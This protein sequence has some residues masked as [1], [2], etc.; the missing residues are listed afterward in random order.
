MRFVLE[1]YLLRGLPRE[2][3]GLGN[4]GGGGGDIPAAFTPAAAPWA[5]ATEGPWKVGDA[6]K[7][8]EWWETI[9]E[10][11]AREHV[12]AKG[13]KNPAELALAN[14][15]LTKMQRGATDVVG[16][17]GK[18]ADDNAWN[19]FYTKL[20]RPAAPTDYN[21]TFGEGVQVDAAMLDFGKDLFHKM[22][23][24]NNR[25][26]QAAN[27]WNEFI[28][29]QNEAHIAEAN[30][31]NTE[32]LAA[33]ELKWGAD[34]NTNRAAGERVVQSL[35]LGAEIMDA[36]QN[37]IGA[38]P[39]V[40]LLALIGRK[41]DEGTLLGNGGSNSDPN[42]PANMTKEQANAKIAELQGDVE[43]QKK[44]TDGKHPGHKE[45]VDRMQKLFMKA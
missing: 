34:L 8:R 13:Y 37:S 23:L 16:L 28:G 2:G 44:Y 36:V 26:Q 25:A 33:L 42:D 6:G 4:G 19:E 9:P 40:E 14:Y 31:A 20:G 3:D 22:G 21:L 1:K 38:A 39:L 10:P 27:A 43:F 15:S 29:K 30:K 41:S 12:K 17:P 32:A 18:D 24:P 5:A 35:G 7:E 11:E 45:A